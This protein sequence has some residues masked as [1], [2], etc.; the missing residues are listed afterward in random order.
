M[1]FAYLCDAKVK[2]ELFMKQKVPLSGYSL[3]IS[4]AVLA[5][6]SGIV[7]LELKKGEGELALFAVA[8]MMMLCIMALVYMPLSVSVDENSLDIH[9]SLAIKSIPLGEIESVMLCP[10]TMS[11]RRI[12]GSGGWFGYWGWFREPSIGRYFAYYGK[13]SD[14]F[15]VRLKNGRQY[16]IGCEHP[17]EMVKQI[18]RKIW[19][20]SE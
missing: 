7:L 10:P 6:L 20:K 8:I 5:V 3:S 12:C 18:D 19:K 2:N 4:V 15:V 9:R 17:K 11:E 16:L 1:F 14:C 13:A